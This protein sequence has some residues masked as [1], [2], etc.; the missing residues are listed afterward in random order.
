MILKIDAFV[1]KFAAKRVVSCIPSGCS[2]V[3]PPFSVSPEF[4]LRSGGHW[5]KLLFQFL[6]KLNGIVLMLIF[7]IESVKPGWFTTLNEIKTGI[8]FKNTEVKAEAFF[9]KWKTGCA[10]N[11][12]LLLNDIAGLIQTGKTTAMRRIAFWET[13]VSR[14]DGTQLWTTLAPQ[15]NSAVMYRGFQG[16]PWC[17]ETPVSR[18][19]HVWSLL[20]SSRRLIAVHWEN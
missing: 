16:S 4:P 9:I 11:E 13:G 12:I 3:S 20:L 7:S 18:Q 10:C 19:L 2:F 5:N 8:F 14:H 17:R 6:V 15:Y 1:G